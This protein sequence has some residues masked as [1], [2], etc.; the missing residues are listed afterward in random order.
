MSPESLGLVVQKQFRRTFWVVRRKKGLFLIA[1]TL[2]ILCV[3]Q[4]RDRRAVGGVL[5]VYMV[6]KDGFLLIRFRRRRCRRGRV[7]LLSSKKTDR[8]LQENRVLIGMET[9]C[10]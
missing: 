1:L 7:S 9:R 10:Y 8:G 4:L 3:G 2:C 6:A 5:L